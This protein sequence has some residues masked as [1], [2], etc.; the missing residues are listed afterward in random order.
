MKRALFPDGVAFALADPALAKE[1][2]HPDEA[3]LAAR[4]SASRRQEFALGRACARR[5]L[6]ELGIR[7][8]PVLRG[9][10]REPR[11]PDGVIGSLTHTDG[12]CAAAAA[13]R[14]ALQAL[15]L[16][17]E[18]GPLS[19]RAARRVLS[20]DERA[21][22]SELSASLGRDFETLAFSAKESVFKAVFPL[23]GVRLTFRDAA[24]AVDPQAQRFTATLVREHRGAL[25]RGASLEGRYAFIEGCAVTS[26]VVRR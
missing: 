4:M 3:K 9:A 19:A 13:R 22:L 7:G 1:P 17:A 8:V 11:W 21:H 16:D 24:I 6:A 20:E 23:A 5:A 10:G 2:L 25:P 14:G 18:S 26:V 12:F 15:G